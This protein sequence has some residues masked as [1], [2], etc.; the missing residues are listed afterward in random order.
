LNRGTT[1]NVG[2]APTTGFSA[3][4]YSHLIPGLTHTR[5]VGQLIDPNCVPANGYQPDA[6]VPS[7]A[8][9]WLAAAKT[10]DALFIAAS[11]IPTGLRIQRVSGANQITSVRAAAFSAA[12]ILVHRAALELDIDP[13]EF[14]IVDPRTHISKSLQLPA[15]QITDHLVNGSGFC[16]HLA[17]PDSSGQPR[18][19]T[20][21]K[22]IFSD[23]T[24]FPL[25]EYRGSTNGI[26]HSEQCDQS[27][28]LC[29]QRYGNQPYHGL[30]DWRLG[31]SFLE[32]MYDSKFACGLDGD[33]GSQS[34]IDWLPLAKR[35]ATELV[36]KYGG[37][38]EVVEVGKLHALRTDRKQSHWALVVHP[39]WDLDN[40][41]GILAEAV[42]NLGADVQFTDTFDLSRRQVSERERLRRLWNQ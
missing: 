29:L 41:T 34:L 13:E 30:L 14:D 5:L 21:I 27:C 6:T 36:T 8:N 18:L 19:V 22:S 20:M 37:G 9:I 38:G 25:K 23:T 7:F 3:D 16:E 17:L 15:L 1:S 28:Y 4:C 2:T 11:T 26:Q 35:Y 32:S 24:A 40:P 10:T 31:L 42:R 12:F 39:L 33:F